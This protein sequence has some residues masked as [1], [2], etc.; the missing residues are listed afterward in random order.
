M[1]TTW[2]S[3]WLLK[4]FCPD[5]LKIETRVPNRHFANINSTPAEDELSD[6][7]LTEMK[8]HKSNSDSLENLGVRLL[9][10]RC[11][12]WECKTN[13]GCNILLWVQVSSVLLSKQKVYRKCACCQAKDHSVILASHSSQGRDAFSLKKKFFFFS[14]TNIYLCHF[15][16]WFLFYY[17]FICACNFFWRG[18]SLRLQDLSS[19]IRIGPRPQQWKCQILTTRPPANSPKVLF[20]FS[21]CTVDFFLLSYF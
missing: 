9:Q 3:P 12:I 21:L 14:K 1:H 19:P 10:A 8:G 15:F 13:C 7:K 18:W 11:V 20:Y 4:D 16:E 6:V 5:N 2:N 17:Y